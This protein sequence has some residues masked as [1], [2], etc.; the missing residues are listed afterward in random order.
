[1]TKTD[2]QIKDTRILVKESLILDKM[3]FAKD[4]KVEG[5]QCPGYVN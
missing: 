1:M 4:W 5:T 2:N 3:I